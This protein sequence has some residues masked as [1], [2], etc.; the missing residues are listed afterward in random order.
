M[1]A[2]L[3]VSKI[4]SSSEVITQAL[5]GDLHVCQEAGF[6][7]AEE[8]TSTGAIESHPDLY[9][10]HPAGAV[11]WP[12]E[13]LIRDE[14]SGLIYNQTFTKSAEKQSILDGTRAGLA[15]IT[16]S[17]SLMDELCSV[18]D[19]FIT[20]ALYNAPFTDPVTHINAKVNRST[21]IVDLPPERA[22]RLF[23][24]EDGHR[25]AIGVCDQFGSLNIESYLK[26]IASCYETGLAGAINFGSG[27]AG[28][29]SYI[30]YNMGSSLYYGV[31]PGKATV[32]VCVVPY[33]LNRRQREGMPKHLHWIK[34]K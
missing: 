14:E 24:A 22:A 12:N 21:T 29:G 26:R 15:K 17:S 11:L 28:I 2:I 19:E 23:L 3:K 20:N 6:M 27:G 13:A 10:K 31:I 7:H 1:S 34:K 4:L 9:F 8:I 18:A 30:I 33:R 16:K 25:L 32:L 5:A